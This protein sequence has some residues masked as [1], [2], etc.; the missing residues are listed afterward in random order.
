M[1]ME[2]IRKQAVE[3]GRELAREYINIITKNKLSY[4]VDSRKSIMKRARRKF[5]IPA[6]RQIPKIILFLTYRSM[7][8]ELRRNG[9]D[10]ELDGSNIIIYKK[11]ESYLNDNIC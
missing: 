8:T 2:E 6:W 9:F 10:Y 1:L 3:F 11:S 5:K 7:R 4:Y